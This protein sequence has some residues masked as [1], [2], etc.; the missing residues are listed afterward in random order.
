MN[1]LSGRVVSQ[2][3]SIKKVM[4]N[5]KNNKAMRINKDENSKDKQLAL[6]LFNYGLV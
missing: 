2:T 6:S 5:K 3:R 4:E 1:L